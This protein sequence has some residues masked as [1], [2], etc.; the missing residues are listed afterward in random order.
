MNKQQT[1]TIA[2]VQYDAHTGTRIASTAPNES[3]AI[4]KQ[5]SAKVSHQL[6]ARQQKSLTL[7]RS[8]VTPPVRKTPIRIHSS[9][10]HKSPMIRK[11]AA[12]DIAAPSQKKQLTTPAAKPDVAVIRHP[13]QNKVQHAQTSIAIAP[14]PAQVI[15]EQAIAEALAKARPAK[16][17]KRRSFIKLHPRVFSRTSAALAIVLLAGYVTYLNLPGISVR[18]AA[19]QAGINATMPSY[20]PSGYHLNGPVA[21][22]NGTVTM[23]FAA[24]ASSNKFTLTQSKSSWDSLSLQQNLVSK[25][26]GENYQSYSTNGIT[27]YTYGTN[28]SWVNGGILHTIDSTA[29]LSNDQL[30]RIATSM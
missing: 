6:H 19:A 18:V 3:V 15:K 24:N 13:I 12:M 7:R 23:D 8:H 5:P 2:G 27:L 28:A 20:H 4:N 30:T 29:T 9:Q 11:F 22:T 16:P 21:Y 25:V 17:L 10:I 26:A 14:R 1:V